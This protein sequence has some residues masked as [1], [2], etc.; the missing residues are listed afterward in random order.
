MTEN[1]GNIDGAANA[2]QTEPKTLHTLLEVTF[3][4]LCTFVAGTGK[5]DVLLIAAENSSIRPRLCR[6]ASVLLFRDEDFMAAP[7][8]AFNESFVDANGKVLCAWNL[9]GCDVEIRPEGLL[10][11]QQQQ[12]GVTPIAKEPSYEKIL[13]LRTFSGRVDPRWVQGSIA[14]DDLVSARIHLPHGRVGCNLESKEEWLM[15]KPE[16]KPDLTQAKKLGQTVTYR[17]EATTPVNFVELNADNYRTGGQQVLR[18][19]AGARIGISSLCAATGE[20]VSEERDVLAYYDL[21][22]Q[23]IPVD[24][25]HRPVTRKSFEGEVRPAQSACPPIQQELGS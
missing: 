15:L 5:I 25:R 21:C 16:T 1:F 22:A 7:G 9:A 14:S 19:R 12:L 2:E 4:G 24:Q 10:P 18:L 17:L 20:N 6:H 3:A 13:D 8:G 11:T 23:P